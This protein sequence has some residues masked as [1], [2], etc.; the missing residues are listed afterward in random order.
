MK[1]KDFSPES[2]AISGGHDPG[3]ANNSIKPPIYQTSTFKFNTAEEGKAFFEKAKGDAP[4]EE[5]NASL[6]YTR[7]NH[8]N[9]ITAEFRL[10]QLDGAE[11]AAFFES[12]MAAI[13]T[14]ILTFCHAGDLILMS[15]PLYGGTDTFIKKHA[16]Q[17]GIEWAEFEPG[18]SAEDIRQLIKAHPKAGRLKMIYL[19]TPA[20]PT[21]SLTDIEM[22]KDLRDEL[23][24]EAI[25]AVDNTYMGP[26]FQKPL[27]HGADLNLYSATKYI[28]GHS[29]IIA[30]AA[31]GSEKVIREVKKK[32]AILG[33]T[34]SPFTSWLLS[35]SMETIGLRM[36]KQA[37]NAQQLAEFLNGHSKVRATHY[38]G[39]LDSSDPLY[40]LFKK[41]NTS[42]GAMIAFEVDGG[43][44]EAFR[45][46]NAL[47]LAHLAISLGSTETLVSHPFTMS[48]SNM[49]EADRLK[50]GITPALIRVSVGIENLQDLIKDF[51]QALNSI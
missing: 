17:F 35:R 7:L 37:S 42:G 33:N 23:A 41:Q 8:P 44:Q 12:G 9:A 4:L 5:R 29:D 51:D 1:H 46:L 20:N 15:S 22:I 13:S 6:I 14:G 34:A 26:V 28:G 47:N 38:L 39:L 16:V 40:P 49:D 11:D 32:R 24:P 36:E 43:Q 2:L 18:A 48:S 25:I 10:A 27:A 30:G 3:S 50:N 21:L 45:F 31:S 19:E